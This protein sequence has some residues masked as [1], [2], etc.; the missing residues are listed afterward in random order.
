VG[1]EATI[2]EQ[3][4]CWFTDDHGSVVFHGL[5]VS[6]HGEQVPQI[7]IQPGDLSNF[8]VYL[9]EQDLVVRIVRLQNGTILAPVKYMQQVSAVLGHP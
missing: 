4:N 2:Q 7:R 5:F 1:C 3:F 6:L 8:A 9:K